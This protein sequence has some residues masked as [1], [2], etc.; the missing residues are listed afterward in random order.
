M[1]S[2][3]KE[4]EDRYQDESFM[5]TDLGKIL[6]ALSS[7]EPASD[8]KKFMHDLFVAEIEAECKTEMEGA[9]KSVQITPKPAESPKERKRNRIYPFLF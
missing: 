2:L 8:L 5:E 9:T 3:A 6:F 1:K 4:V 7:T